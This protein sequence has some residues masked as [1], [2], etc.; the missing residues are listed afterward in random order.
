MYTGEEILYLKFLIRNLRSID[1]D[2]LTVL[3]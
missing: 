2:E 3:P 1:L